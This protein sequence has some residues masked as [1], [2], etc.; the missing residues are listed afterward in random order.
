VVARQAQMARAAGAASVATVATAAVRS[1]ANRDALVAAVERAAGVEVRILSGE[2]EAGFAFAGATAGLRVPPAD[3]VGVADV[4]GGSSELVCGTVAAGVE[5][6]ASLMVGS[7]FLADLYLH[8]DP[9][10]PEEL[11]AA[12]RHVAEVFDGLEVPPTEA[13]FAVGGSATSLRTLAG[14]HLSAETLRDAVARLCSRPSAAAAPALGLHAERVRIL[15]AGMV[16]LEQAVAAFGRPL[17]IAGGGLREGVVLR[18]LR[19]VAAWESDEDGQG[20]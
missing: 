18:E 8:H 7:G 15:P 4:G 12:R 3:A 11:A 2:E 9:P 6:S 20:T 13:A 1:A 10:T 16:I 19:R 17:Q 5:W 14:D